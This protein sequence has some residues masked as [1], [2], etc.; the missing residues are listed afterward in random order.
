MSSTTVPAIWALSGLAITTVISLIYVGILFVFMSIIL[1]AL[2][3]LSR[4]I[5]KMIFEFI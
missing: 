2:I 4:A 5:Y 3:L 1:W